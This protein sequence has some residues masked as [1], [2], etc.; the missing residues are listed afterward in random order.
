MKGIYLDHGSATP[1]DPR[2]VS[3][4]ERYLTDSYG[5]PSSLHSAG[6]EAKK[7]VKEARTKL[8][9]L[10]NAENEASII[11]TSGATESNNLATR[12][13]AR[14]NVK[15]GK[16]VVASAIEHISV[17]NPMK[18][19]QKSSFELTLVPVALVLPALVNLEAT[20]PFLYLWW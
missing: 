12:G 3:F 15:K 14:R 4:A 19:L 8:A 18:E 20:L 6:L 17:L 13:T 1:V 7:A 11:F 16:R 10:I 9:G 5:N 2:V